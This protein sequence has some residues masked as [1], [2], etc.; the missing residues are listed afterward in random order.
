MKNMKKLLLLA[1]VFALAGCNGGQTSSSS[2]SETSS[3]M[4]SSVSSSTSSEETFDTE[5]FGQVKDTI[6]ALGNNYYAS[7]YYF[8]FSG[9]QV[10]V[11]MNEMVTTPKGVLNMSTKSGMAIAKNSTGATK[12]YRFQVDFDAEGDD[13]ATM[14]LPSYHEAYMV[15]D[16]FNTDQS[17]V[18]EMN[19]ENYDFL[20]S[21]PTVN[22]IQSLSDS[23]H[24]ALGLRKPKFNNMFEQGVDAD[25]YVTFTTTNFAVAQVF[26]ENF[27]Y[28]RLEGYSSMYNSEAYELL[29]SSVDTTDLSG[30]QTIF[31]VIDMDTY[32]ALDV[33]VILSAFA[34]DTPYI[35]RTLV[36]LSQVPTEEVADYDYFSNIVP[37]TFYEEGPGEEPEDVKTKR[38]AFKAQLEDLMEYN[39]TINFTGGADL[40]ASAQ[41]TAK[42]VSPNAFSFGDGTS[43]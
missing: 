17:V 3:S 38:A 29:F 15:Y 42:V 5:L 33:Q 9:D 27:S 12:G 18:V 26:L 2:S 43:I 20:Y 30:T 22:D 4:S 32:I 11:S 35:E 40:F 28:G 10:F 1:A 34:E 14:F 16:G 41:Y 8:S 19:Q 31:T 24:N 21:V 6:N 39:Y 23:Y 36:A 25:G 7:D 13:S 37:E